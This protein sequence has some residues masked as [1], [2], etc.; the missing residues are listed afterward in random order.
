MAKVVTRVAKA[1]L[2]IVLLGTTGEGESLTK[3]KELTE[4]N[5]L[6]KEE[7]IQATQVARKALDDAGFEEAPLCVGTGGKPFLLVLAFA[8]TSFLLCRRVS[9]Y[10]IRIP[11]LNFC[12]DLQQH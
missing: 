10:P 5:H 9:I 11:D 6:S 12:L 8:E 3:W 4:A 1:G 2:G 7:R